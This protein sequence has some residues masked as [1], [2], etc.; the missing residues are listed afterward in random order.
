MNIKPQLAY[1]P[2]Y[3]YGSYKKQKLHQNDIDN[4]GKVASDM[5]QNFLEQNQEVVDE[6]TSIF[7]K[8]KKLTAKLS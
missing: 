3:S 2:M 8:I 1:S 5:V 4:I 7:C 6:L